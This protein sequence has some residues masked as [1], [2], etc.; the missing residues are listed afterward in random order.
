MTIAE[1]NALMWPELSNAHKSDTLIN[2]WAKD[3]VR[4]YGCCQY[5]DYP[6]S[7]RHTVW[8]MSDENGAL[9]PDE[10]SYT[11]LLERNN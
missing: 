4:G 3:T 2:D 7:Y 1:K 5:V 10:S 11:P 8:D 9:M 6:H